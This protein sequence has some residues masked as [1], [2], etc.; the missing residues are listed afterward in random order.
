MSPARRTMILLATLGLGGVLIATAHSAS[1]GLRPHW[2]VSGWAFALVYA[3]ALGIESRRAWRGEAGNAWWRFCGSLLILSGFLAHT[4]T[5]IPQGGLELIMW[6]LF[7][8]ALASL[9]FGGI[10]AWVLR[11]AEGATEPQWRSVYFPAAYSLLVV[12][13]IH[14][15]LSHAHGFLAA[16]FGMSP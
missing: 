13:G 10:S 16:T 3:I 5:R 8:V 1:D 11:K 9:F 2:F 7:L 14:A 15:I 12:G 4:Q 6:G